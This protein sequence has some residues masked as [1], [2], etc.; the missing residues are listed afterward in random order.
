MLVLPS[1]HNVD[2]KLS[3]GFFQRYWDFLVTL[4]DLASASPSVINFSRPEGLEGVSQSQSAVTPLHLRYYR[5]WSGIIQ[6]SLPV[7]GI[8]LKL[9][10]PPAGLV[11]NEVKVDPDEDDDY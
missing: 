11:P 5:L 2:N 10:R 6:G 7:L 3:Y 4:E 1:F 9:N 8:G